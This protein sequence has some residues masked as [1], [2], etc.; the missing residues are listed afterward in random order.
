MSEPSYGDGKESTLSL[1]ITVDR[2]IALTQIKNG[3][4]P[5][6]GNIHTG[7]LKTAP[8]KLVD[9]AV[10]QKCMQEFQKHFSL[11]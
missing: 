8:S 11:C 4:A 1:Q 7:L 2:Q 5:G 9:K 10:M 3:K 6:L